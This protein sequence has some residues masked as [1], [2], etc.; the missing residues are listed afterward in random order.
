MTTT[1]VRANGSAHTLPDGQMAGRAVRARRRR[2]LVAVAGVILVA[3]TLTFLAGN[4]SQANTQFDQAHQALEATR[5]RIDTVSQE[6]ATARHD[7][8]ITNG[9]VAVDSTTL[10]N[11]DSKLAGARTALANAQADVSRQTSAIASLHTCLG[12]V[13]RALNA[14]ALSDQNQAV[15]ALN[16][17][18]AS[19][20]NAL[21][22]NG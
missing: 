12:G 19:C 14:L 10:T 20:L 1:D 7:L 21:S 5:Y 2:W 8:D 22:A 6:L 11:D 9:Q 18:S 15:D 4:E 17:V 13:E 16:A 3:A